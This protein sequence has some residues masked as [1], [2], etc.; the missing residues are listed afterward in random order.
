MVIAREPAS[1][2]IAAVRAASPSLPAGSW[3]EPAVKTIF[4]LSCGS[5]D[6]CCSSRTPGLEPA[7]AGGGRTGGAALL[8]A[9][10]NA[11][12]GLTEPIDGA[13]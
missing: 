11:A 8:E 4:T 10:A 9:A 12:A 1:A 7:A 3:A 5:T 6:F 2:I 13:R